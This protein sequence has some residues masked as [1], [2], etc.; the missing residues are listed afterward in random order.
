MTL[1]QLSSELNKRR[2]ELGIGCPALARRAGISLR[3]VQRALS[4]DS[5]ADP[6]FG[7][8]LAIAE[9]M[10]MTIS[11]RAKN[12]DAFKQERA[13]QKAQELVAQAQGTSG[14]EAQAVPP[15]ELKRMK[16]QTARGLLSGSPRK[17]WAV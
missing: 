11:L 5:A 8:L 1:K 15:S 14:L 7:T 10:G 12:A 9:A 17:L 2:R 6:S 3:T 16:K 13:E 4:Y